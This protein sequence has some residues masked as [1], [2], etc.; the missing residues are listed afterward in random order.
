MKFCEQC[1]NK[2]NDNAKFCPGCGAPVQEEVTGA[3]RTS[4]NTQIRH[5]TGNVQGTMTEYL[6]RCVLLERNVHIQTQFVNKLT[7]KMTALGYKQE[8]RSPNRPCHREFALESNDASMFGS[9]AILGAIVGAFTG[10]WIAGLLIGGFAVSGLF[11]VWRALEVAGDNKRLDEAYNQQMAQYNAAVSRDRQRVEQE[12]REKAKLAEII[13]E[14]ERKK[15]EIIKVRD[16]FYDVDILFPKYRNMVAVCSLY[17]Y[18]LSKRYSELEGPDGAYNRYETEI[19]L[20]RIITQL[21]VVIHKLEQIKANQYMLY[22]AIQQGNSITKKLLDESVRQSQIAEK[23][24]QNTAKAAHYSEIAAN[25]T[26]ACAW[27]E[28]A[29]YAELRRLNNRVSR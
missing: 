12:L 24:A 28:A 4:T 2:I 17:E 18:F 9:G 14:A 10:S 23:V 15:E 3:I 19:R 27:L 21:D 6:K 11:I 20:D 25:N 8:F 26:E 5:T 22:D 7:K 13:K 29:N 16:R 1:G